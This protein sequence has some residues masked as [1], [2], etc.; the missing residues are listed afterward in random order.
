MGTMR[1]QLSAVVAAV[2]TLFIFTAASVN[3][4]TI[5]DNFFWIIETDYA[6][7]NPVPDPT[8]SPYDD[9]VLFGLDEESE[10]WGFIQY[11]SGIFDGVSLKATGTEF[12]TYSSGKFNASIAI[13]N[14]T[15]T[16]FYPGIDEI[17]FT[18]GKLTSVILTAYFDFGVG[19]VNDPSTGEYYFTGQP[20]TFFLKNLPNDENV[21][22]SGEFYFAIVDPHQ[23][24]VAAP[25]PVPGA[26]WL[27]GSG[28]IGLVGLRR[29]QRN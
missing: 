28:L 24:V 10:V 1:I 12:V 27:F 6:Y 22:S 3:A 17:T 16:A 15:Q 13:G 19:D 21:Y 26:V 14:H 25:V 7:R 4:A 2:A 5:T 18:N 20:S 29:K 8:G 23:N 9:D 11:D